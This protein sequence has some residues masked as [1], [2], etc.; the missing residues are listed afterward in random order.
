VLH[1]AAQ[2][3]LEILSA[4]RS[5]QIAGLSQTLEELDKERRAGEALRKRVEETENALAQARAECE[6]L[7]VVETCKSAEMIDWCVCVWLR[8]LVLVSVSF[9][10]CLCFM[11]LSVSVVNMARNVRG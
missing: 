3:Q 11:S 9:W 10:V 7:R 2:A 8:L 6:G 5:G 1:A 4:E